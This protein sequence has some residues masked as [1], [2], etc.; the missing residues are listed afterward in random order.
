MNPSKIRSDLSINIQKPNNHIFQNIKINFYKFC[1][2]Y[3]K[4]SFTVF[5]EAGNALSALIDFI[6]FVFGVE[7]TSMIYLAKR[8]H[9]IFT[10]PNYLYRI[11]IS[12]EAL[13][14]LKL[15]S[16]LEIAWGRWNWILAVN[17]LKRSFIFEGIIRTLSRASLLFFF[18]AFTLNLLVCSIFSVNPIVSFNLR[19]LSSFNQDHLGRGLSISN[20]I[21]SKIVLG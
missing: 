9:A 11:Q 2:N 6:W 15:A 12:D 10:N 21:I 13:E 7:D 19:F 1:L 17:L 5:F 4:I 18:R 16:T 14:D 3:N 20:W 8:F